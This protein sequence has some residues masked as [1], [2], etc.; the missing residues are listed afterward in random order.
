MGREA[1]ERGSDGVRAGPQLADMIPFG[2][3]I[4]VGHHSERGHRAH[5]NRID[6]AMRLAVDNDRQAA[7]MRSRAA[8]IEA[9]AKQA[10]YSDDPDAIE[11][12]TEKIA[13]L[14]TERDAVKQANAE[15]RKTHRDELRAMTSPYARDRALPYPRY[16]ATNLTGNIGRLRKRLEQLQRPAVDRIIVARFDSRCAECGAPLPSWRQHPLQQAG[17]RT[18]RGVRVMTD[19]LRISDSGDIEAQPLAWDGEPLYSPDTVREAL[20]DAKPFG[21]IPGQLSIGEPSDGE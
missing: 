11:R 8:N 21:Q 9:A 17:R 1:R 5:I 12:L 6:S 13:K 3:P 7:E 4:L 10:I 19:Q 18:L 14:E 20:L 16:V 2:Q 15:Y